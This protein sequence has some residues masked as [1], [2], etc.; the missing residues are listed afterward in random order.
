MPQLPR[1]E[2]RED[3]LKYVKLWMIPL[4]REHCSTQKAKELGHDFEKMS[5]SC[6]E[7][8]TPE[9]LEG[10]WDKACIGREV[11]KHWLREPNVS[12]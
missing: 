7:M 2:T 6:F 12:L 8:L 5:N 11:P 3:I 9:I 4:W 1:M 10:Y